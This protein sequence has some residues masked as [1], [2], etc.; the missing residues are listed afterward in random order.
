[1]FLP[2]MFAYR[3]ILAGNI[4]ME[5]PNLR[6]KK[7]REQYRNDVACTSPEVAGDQLLPTF[8]KGTPTIS[9]EVYAE[10]YRL[11]R[12]EFEANEGYTKAA[13]TQGDGKNI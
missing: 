7:V 12:K 3:S 2:G 9:D 5:V 8:S 11:W 4:P 13:F 6:D 1:M 10:Q